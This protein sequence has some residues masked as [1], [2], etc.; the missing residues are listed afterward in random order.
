MAIPSD[1]QPEPSGDDRLW[2]LLTYL[3]SPWVSIIILLME[4]KKQ[5]PFLKYHYMQALILGAGEVV[6]NTVLTP[7]GI[8]CLL[9][10][11]TIVYNV[12]LCY[13][14]NKGEYFDVPGIG[15][16]VRKQGWG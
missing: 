16:W 9:W 5:R 6:V 7:L 8:G 2:G 12:W 3:F 13:R 15:S 11:V 4:S 1:L 14:A 10:V